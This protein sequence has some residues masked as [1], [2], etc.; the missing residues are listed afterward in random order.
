MVEH[1]PSKLK[2]LSSNPTPEL[3]KKKK[4]TG[5]LTS[6]RNLDLVNSIVCSLTFYNQLIQKYFDKEY[7]RKI[8]LY[9]VC[10]CVCVCVC[11]WRERKC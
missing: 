2:A 7:F 6:L 11:V 1:L 3:Q 4:Y 8:N 10:V 9:S 5:K